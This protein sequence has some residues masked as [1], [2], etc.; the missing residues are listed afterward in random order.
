MIVRTAH[1]Q[2]GLRALVFDVVVLLLVFDVVVLLFFRAL[3]FD[4]V[5]L[6]F[7]L[8]HVFTAG[9]FRSVRIKSRVNFS[10]A[11]RQWQFLLTVMLHSTWA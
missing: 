5:V 6:R 7:V 4:V 1:V 9:I 11:N 2:I 3:V 8:R 10:V